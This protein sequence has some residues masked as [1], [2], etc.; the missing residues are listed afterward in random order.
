MLYLKG[1]MFNQKGRML[2][3]KGRKFNLKGRMLYLKARNFN[4][5]GT[6]CP[7]SGKIFSKIAWTLLKL[8]TKKGCSH[9]ENSLF[10]S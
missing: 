3:L 7:K 8:C 1:R 5:K 6:V 2:N 4:P 10:D 9:G